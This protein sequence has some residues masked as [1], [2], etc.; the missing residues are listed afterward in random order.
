M[1]SRCDF[2]NKP[3]RGLFK[4]WKQPVFYNFDQDLTKEIL[5][6]IIV[7]L[8]N[9]GYTVFR[10]TCDLRPSNQNLIKQLKIDVMKNEDKTYS[11]R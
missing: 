8:Y 5:F 10:M 6:E 4:K 7:Q 9:S 2:L 3:P 1:P 11:V